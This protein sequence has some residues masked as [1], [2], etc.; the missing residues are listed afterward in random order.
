MKIF[1]LWQKTKLLVLVLLSSIARLPG[2]MNCHTSDKRN[3]VVIIYLQLLDSKSFPYVIL[4]HLHCLPNSTWVILESH[5]RT[6]HVVH[7]SWNVMAHRGARDGKWRGN[8][9]IEWVTST[10]HTTSV[11]G[12]S[13]ITAADLCTSAAGSRMNWRPPADL[14]WL[15]CFA[16]RQN[17]VSACV[18]SDF[19]WPLTLLKGFMKNE[20][21]FSLNKCGEG[22][23]LLNIC[24]FYWI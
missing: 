13:S 20:V 1:C 16:K 14:N 15:I 10:L 12:V 17:L 4:L 18:P 22:L 2:F 24:H 23:K 7:S 8:W 21:P 11:H 5:S 6:E 9:R 19:N 3:S